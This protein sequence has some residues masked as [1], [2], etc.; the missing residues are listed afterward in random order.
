[1]NKGRKLKLDK[2][3]TPLPANESDEI[4]PNGIFNFNISRIL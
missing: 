1:M 4:Y 2:K 3:Y